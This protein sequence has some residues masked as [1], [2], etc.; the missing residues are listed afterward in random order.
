MC[1]I[2]CICLWAYAVGKV[3]C[4]M[5]LPLPLNYCWPQ[6]SNIYPKFWLLYRTPYFLCIHHVWPLLLEQATIPLYPLY[7]TAG[8]ADH[9]K[10]LQMLIDTMAISNG[11]VLPDLIRQALPAPISH[12]IIKCKHCSMPLTCPSKSNPYSHA[13]CN[14]PGHTFPSSHG[15]TLIFPLPTSCLSLD[16]SVDH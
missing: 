8:A 13:F 6:L 7:I 11:F 16:P 1:I 10:L 5:P 4:S 9:T 12:G 14:A 2:N 15:P 3:L